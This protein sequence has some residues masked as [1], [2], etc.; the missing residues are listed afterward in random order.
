MVTELARNWWLL[1]IRGLA[2]IS[3]AIGAFLWPG[4]TLAVLVLLI[5]SYA[6]VDG[7]FALIAGIRARR[8]LI[9]LEGVAGI[10]LGA[11]TLV[12]PG[13][14]ALILLYF[15]ATWSIITGIFEIAAAV[16]LRKVIDNEWMLILSGILSVLFG[17]VLFVYPGTG[18][19]SVVWLIGL[20]ALLFGVVTLGL[21]FRL[22]GLH[23]STDRRVTGVA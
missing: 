6:L 21:A 1:A 18:A 12:W 7:L 9:A 15:I 22:R 14:T 2:A 16:Q 19:L 5:G 11:L 17:I 20:Y 10:I 3:F 23:N 8:W 13:I 4:L